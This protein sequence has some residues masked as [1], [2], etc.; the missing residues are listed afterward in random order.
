M[1]LLMAG[2]I[3]QLYKIISVIFPQHL[4]CCNSIHS[5]H[6]NIHE[7]K[8]KALSGLKS[9]GETFPG[10]IERYLKLF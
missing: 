7:N 3:N 10:V 2:D 1:I 8:V 4:P 6:F 9:L 5:T